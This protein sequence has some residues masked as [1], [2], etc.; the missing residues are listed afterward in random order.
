MTVYVRRIATN[1]DITREIS[2]EKD[3]YENFFKSE[4][5][6]IFINKNDESKSKYEIKITW[7][8]EASK[9]DP[10]LSGDFKQLLRD[11]GGFQIGDV[12][13][14]Y[15]TK[16]TID[17]KSKFEIDLIKKDN[18]LNI[19]L[20]RLYTF[21]EESRH[22]IINI[23][24]TN[25]E[26]RYIEWIKKQTIE[27]GPQ[28]GEP[29]DE[30]G[31]IKPY[32]TVLKRKIAGEQSY[33]DIDNEN[34]IFN[35]MNQINQTAKDSKGHK[36]DSSAIKSYYKFLKEKNNPSDSTCINYDQ[37]IYYG[38]PGS[39][40]SHKIFKKIEQLEDSQKTRIVFHPEYSNAD[41]IGQILLVQD[42][43]G[44]DYRFKAGPFTQ[45]LKK[46]LLNPNKAYYLIIE[47]INRGNAAAIFGD[48]FQLLDRDLNGISKYGIKNV[49]INAFIRS[50]GKD[51]YITKRSEIEPEITINGKVFNDESD[52]YLPQN[53][54]ILATMNT[55][56]QNVFVLDNA[57][58]RRWNME[59]IENKFDLSDPDSKRQSEAIIEGF[60]NLTWADFL[61]RINIEISKRGNT[62]GISSM[63]DKRLGCWFIKPDIALGNTISLDLF[64]EKVLKYLWDD[65]FRF[66]R[67]E[68]F[69]NKYDSF[70]ALSEGFKNKENIFLDDSIMKTVPNKDTQDIDG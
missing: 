27:S 50:K 56:D 12:V 9:Q 31:T 28:K 23:D 10:R 5:E 66:S 68:V 52:L 39:G 49:D 3:T 2:I 36:R 60:G 30:E 32:V 6:F 47:E 69:N 45:I 61:K 26:E 51:I 62:T 57:F 54:S 55:S 18:P 42:E 43:E 41:F 67:K 58:Q 38:V 8:D 13:L 37:I 20:T 59:L 7:K 35:I 33:F 53:L 25:N 29:Y 46:A 17:N 34:Q 22:I 14:I 11:D 40:K 48:V 1:H 70:E 4:N 21:G 19:A 63:E 64:S 16:E 65:A 44:I 15:Q 24:K